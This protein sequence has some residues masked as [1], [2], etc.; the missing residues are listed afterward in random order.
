MLDIRACIPLLLSAPSL[1][2]SSLPNF[3]SVTLSKPTG[4]RQAV[5]SKISGDKQMRLHCPCAFL[6]AVHGS[7]TGDYQHLFR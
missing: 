7:E 1:C 6:A 5:M 3:E 2:S 4:L